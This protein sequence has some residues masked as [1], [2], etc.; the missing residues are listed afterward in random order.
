VH[1]WCKKSGANLMVMQPSL[2][3]SLDT[4]ATGSSEGRYCTN[5]TA[6]TCMNRLF[7]CLHTVSA[8]MQATCMSALLLTT[9]TAGFYQTPR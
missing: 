9:S 6:A 7:P 2:P 8:G 4:K 5:S 3:R 1:I